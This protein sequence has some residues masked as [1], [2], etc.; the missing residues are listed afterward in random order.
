MFF[1]FFNKNNYCQKI[2]NREKILSRFVGKEVIATYDNENRYY[3]HT[4]HSTYIKDKNFDAKYVL[5]LFNSNLFKFY[6]RKTNSQGGD[7]FPQVRISSVENLPIKI[8][9]KEIQQPII[10]LVDQI[11]TLKKENPNANTS[12]LENDIDK[13]VYELYELSPEE[14]EVVK[15]S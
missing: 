11:L 3:E 5:G 14:I 12:A 13:L 6:Y 2:F 1:S 8:A 9:T 7:I 4:L 10:S 15:G